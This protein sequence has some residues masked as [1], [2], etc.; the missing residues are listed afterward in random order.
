MTTGDEEDDDGNER[1]G[2]H[3]AVLAAAKEPAAT[4]NCGLILAII[5]TQNL[6]Y[7]FCNF[8]LAACWYW[9]PV[10]RIKIY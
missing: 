2:N 4:Y 6:N 1:F 7:Y 3:F 5:A 9:S 10:G 8:M